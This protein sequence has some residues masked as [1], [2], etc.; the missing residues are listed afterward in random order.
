MGPAGRDMGA[1]RI[2]AGA[3]RG[4][5]A[6]RGGG[7]DPGHGHDAD[8]VVRPPVRLRDQGG[9]GRHAGPLPGRARELLV[10]RGQRVVVVQPLDGSAA[11]RLPGLGVGAPERVRRA[12]RVR[13]GGGVQLPPAGTG[14]GGRDLPARQRAR[15]DRR[16][17]LR[18]G[19]GHAADPAL[20]GAAAGAAHRP[21]H[22]RRCHR[23]QPVLTSRVF[24][25]DQ[26]G[27]G[28]GARCVQMQGGGGSRR[29]ASATDDNA[30]DARA[31]PREPGLIQTRGPSPAG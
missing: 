23:H 20:G 10:V 30:A 18:P 31:G 7:T 26:A 11:A 21:G 27:S 17:C 19:G 29:G 1:G 8:R 4:E 14:A 12:V 2:R 6:G 9:A 24:R 22:L 28:S 16:L 13:A 5:G 25:L 3:V 15:G